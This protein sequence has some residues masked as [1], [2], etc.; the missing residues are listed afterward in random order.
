MGL[1]LNEKTEIFPLRHGIPFLGFHTYLCDDG[2]IYRRVN[3]QKVEQTRRR[4]QK[5]AKMYKEGR[6]T[7]QKIAASYQGSRAYIK[8]GDTGAIIAK[9]DA[10]FLDIFKEDKELNGLNIEQALRNLNKGGGQ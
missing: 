8:Q 1:E 3:R 6:I 7:A 4:L 5:F 9:L 2:H 10:L